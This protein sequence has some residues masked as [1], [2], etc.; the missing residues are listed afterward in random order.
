MELLVIKQERKEAERGLQ[1]HAVLSHRKEDCRNK[2]IQRYRT[3]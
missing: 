3:T 2:I 1:Q